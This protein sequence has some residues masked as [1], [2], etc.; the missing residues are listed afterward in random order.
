MAFHFHKASI[1]ELMNSNQ[2]KSAET[3]KFREEE[4]KKADLQQVDEAFLREMGQKLELIKTELRKLNFINEELMIENELWQ[5]QYFK[6]QEYIKSKDGNAINVHDI[7]QKNFITTINGLEAE[8]EQKESKI[9]NIMKS[10]KFYEKENA[11]LKRELEARSQIA[12][13]SPSF[14]KDYLRKLEDLE[15]INFHLN[16]ELDQ[17]MYEKRRTIIHTN[18]LSQK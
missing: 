3:F 8:L 1:D 9:A 11:A 13:S 12:P 18:T 5:E 6:L 4:I 7:Y 10:I 14:K 16:N 15:K 17:A 2:N